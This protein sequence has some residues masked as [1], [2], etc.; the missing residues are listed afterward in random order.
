[1][2][3][4]RAYEGDLE[5]WLKY[6]EAEGI[7]DTSNLKGRLSPKLIRRYLHLNDGDWERATLSRRLS[8]FRS[9]L[10]FLRNR[11]MIDID[12]GKLVPAPK[13]D[14]KL[15]RFLKVEEMAELL[16]VPR[17]DRAQGRRDRAMLELMYG[18]GIRVSELVGL[19]RKDVELGEGWVRVMGKG[20]KA[21]EVPF[22]PQAKLALETYMGDLD[23]GVWPLSDE[24]RNALFVNYKGSRLS[25][26]SVA[27]ALRRTLIAWAGSKSVSPH[28]LRHSFATH[29][30]AAGADLRTIQELLGHARISTT[31]RYTHVDLGQLMDE[32]RA[33]HPLNSKK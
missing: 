7:V 28:G 2:H 17:E 4:L 3:T 33:T 16:T 26:R 18:A 9:F 15:P 27:R 29:L 11:S 8:A 6:L 5:G 23:Q 22:G 19:D 1:M 30:L 25:A 10:K 31:Q 24:S 32:Y 12:L 20:S 13:V 14:L 21:R